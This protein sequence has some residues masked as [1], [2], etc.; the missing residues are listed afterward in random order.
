MFWSQNQ[1]Q[2][3]KKN[4]Q[5]QNQSSNLPK[6]LKNYKTMANQ[7]T[8]YPQNGSSTSKKQKAQ[9][10]IKLTYFGIKGLAEPIRLALD[11]MGLDFEDVR[12][13]FSELQAMRDN[14]T[15]KPKSWGL[16]VVEIDGF[17]TNQSYAQLRYLAKLNP[18]ANLYPVDPLEAF[19]VDQIVDSVIDVRTALMPGMYNPI[20]GVINY[21]WNVCDDNL[22]L[23]CVC[24]ETVP[25]FNFFQF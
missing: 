12:V 4:L 20:G 23:G 6:L 18:Y 13:P 19:K 3:K 7:T 5:N 16:P 1:S 21:S 10:H 2:L 8:G 24:V 9:P 14:G 22:Y 25:N 11:H 17:R 15:H